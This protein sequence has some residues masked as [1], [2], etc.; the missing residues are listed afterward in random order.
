MSYFAGGLRFHEQMY[1]IPS[2]QMQISLLSITVGLPPSTFGGAR[3]DQQVMA[4]ALPAAYHY[5][6]P[7]TTDVTS[8]IRYGNVIEGAELDALLKMSRGLSFIL[9]AVYAMFLCFQLW[10]KSRQ[11]VLSWEGD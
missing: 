4:I 9:L 11:G 1:F 2:A 3:A 6:F 7:S 8:G 10:S 5:A